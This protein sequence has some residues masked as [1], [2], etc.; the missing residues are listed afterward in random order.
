MLV[1]LLCF[2]FLTK[3]LY[4]ISSATAKQILPAKQVEQKTL[5][6]EFIK[7]TVKKFDFSTYSC[8]GKTHC[9]HMS[10]CEEAIF[11]LRNCPSQHTDGDRGTGDGCP[12]ERQWC[13]DCSQYI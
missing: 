1:F 6:A 3:R 2:I 4:D 5:S 12:C 7:K 9:L 10:S 11:Y 13:G 8:Q